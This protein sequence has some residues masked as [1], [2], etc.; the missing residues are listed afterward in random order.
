M[1]NIHCPEC[2]P[3]S[4]A[5]F[6]FSYAWHLWHVHGITVTTPAGGWT[7]ARAEAFFAPVIVVT[8]IIEVV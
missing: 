8:L 2:K 3:T 4:G 5:I 6:R 1:N 7:Q